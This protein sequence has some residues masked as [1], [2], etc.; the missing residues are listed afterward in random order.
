MQNN[1]HAGLLEPGGGVAAAS[2]L[3]RHGQGGGYGSGG[4]LTAPPAPAG[5]GRGVVLKIHHEVM[6]KSPS[7]L[8]WG[9]SAAARPAPLLPT[10]QGHR[11][12]PSSQQDRGA[13]LFQFT[14][15]GQK[16]SGSR[17]VHRMAMAAGTGLGSPPQASLLRRTPHGPALGAVPAG[18]GGMNRERGWGRA[19]TV[20]P[21]GKEPQA[22]ITLQG[23]PG[24]L[25]QERGRAGL[26]AG[27]GMEAFLPPPH[28]GVAGVP[29]WPRSA[30]HLLRLP[31]GPARGAANIKPA[32]LPPLSSPRPPRATPR[33]GAACAPLGQTATE[34]KTQRKR[35]RNRGIKPTLPWKKKKSDKGKK[36]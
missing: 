21:P 1:G 7:P 29:P 25:R 30:G 35:K 15:A 13:G 24:Q 27:A 12:V 22:A 8:L 4:V 16:T 5:A 28:H 20:L 19:S 18:H 33:G 6:D 34:P 36:H 23:S 9:A 32:A 3:A 14:A 11:A 2:F 26:R 10:G 17:A 31:P